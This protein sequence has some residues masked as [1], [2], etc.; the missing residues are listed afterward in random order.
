MQYQSIKSCRELSGDFYH[1]PP[2]ILNF[3]LI[4]SVSST[5]KPL[6]EKLTCKKVESASAFGV[7]A[8][9]YFPKLRCRTVAYHHPGGRFVNRLVTVDVIASQG[10]KH[11]IDNDISLLQI[12]ILTVV[13]SQ[14]LNEKW[15]M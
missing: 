13:T 7:T 4:T 9:S 6:L 10:S 11:V 2:Y 8:F 1:P 3:H 14:A 12:H 15:N 5:E